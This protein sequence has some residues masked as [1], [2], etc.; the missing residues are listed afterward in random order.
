VA[1]IGAGIGIAPLRALAEGLRYAP[2]DAVLL[3]R[4]RDRALFEGEFQTLA[5]ERGLELRWLPGRRRN[6][7]SWLGEHPGTG[8]DHTTV[9]GW[10]PDLAERDV[11]VCGPE[12]WVEMVRRTTHRLGLPPG[13]L[14]IETFGG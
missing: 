2:G 3:Y 12:T 4:F 10:V 8:E 7:H 1:F 14:H 11:F 9:A 6:P 13:Q 5:A